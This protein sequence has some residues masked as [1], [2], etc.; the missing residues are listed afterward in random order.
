MN[1][2]LIKQLN[3]NDS[4][5]I[6]SCRYITIYNNDT[7]LNSAIEINGVSLN[8]KPQQQLQIAISSNQVDSQITIRCTQNSVVLIYIREI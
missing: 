2:F 4:E 5:T 1:N 3:L 8:L 7:L 6:Q